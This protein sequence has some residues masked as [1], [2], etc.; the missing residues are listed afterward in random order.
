M[1]NERTI[2]HVRRNMQLYNV[3]TRY[4]HRTSRDSITIRRPDC[5]IKIAI[6]FKA[7]NAQGLSRADDHV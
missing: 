3:I 2:V 6:K 4:R 1:A 5:A 7:W